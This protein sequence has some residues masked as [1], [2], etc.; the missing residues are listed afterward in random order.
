MD[1]NALDQYE[2]SAISVIADLFRSHGVECIEES[3]ILVFQ[4]ETITVDLRLFDRTSQT[5]LIILQLDIRVNIGI[6]CN[7]I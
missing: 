1:I 2:E 6:N 4:K 3:G 7:I 5:D